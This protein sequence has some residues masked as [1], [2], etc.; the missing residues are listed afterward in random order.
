MRTEKGHSA[1]ASLI[2]AL[3][4]RVTLSDR[5]TPMP[6]ATSEAKLDHLR[7]LLRAGPH[8][9][10]EALGLSH[11][12]GAVVQSDDTDGLRLT[13]TEGD[14]VHLRPSGNAPEL[15]LYVEAATQ[16]RAQTLLNHC[17]ASVIEWK[18]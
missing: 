16:E 11:L 8:A 14:Y 9:L 17:M 5:V 12:C 2:Q 15:R 6:T 13:F 4:A 18:A 10:T 3:P 7:Q 1:L